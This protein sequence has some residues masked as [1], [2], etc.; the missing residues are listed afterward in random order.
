LNL[1]SSDIFDRM[2]YYRRGYLTSSDLSLFLRQQCNFDV[3]EEQVARIHPYLDNS[4]TYAI[5]R[6]NFIRATAQHNGDSEE[7]MEREDDEEDQEEG[8]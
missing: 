8:E 2:D 1:A 4:G 5:E 6:D 7:E 3:T